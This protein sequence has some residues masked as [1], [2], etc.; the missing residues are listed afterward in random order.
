MAFLAVLDVSLLSCLMCCVLHTSLYHKNFVGWFESSRAISL[1][2]GLSKQ[3]STVILCIFPI[4]FNSLQVHVTIHIE[5]LWEWMWTKKANMSLTSLTDAW[6]LTI[7][8]PKDL[9]NL[10]DIQEGKL[11]NVC[12][13]KLHSEGPKLLR[14]S[15]YS[16]SW[17][18][19][20]QTSTRALFDQE[21]EIPL[22]FV[23]S[24]CD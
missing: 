3:K 5:K 24:Q 17:L 10:S 18:Q 12:L 15:I 4:F 8:H 21:E 19:A 6:H 16:L 14:P 1:T 9:L 22:G 2:S 7:E 23:W 11:R 13:F 20:Q